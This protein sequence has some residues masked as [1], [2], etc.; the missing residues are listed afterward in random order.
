MKFQRSLDLN[1]V[2]SSVFLLGPR[3][4]GKTSLLRQL[5]AALF[6][7]LLDPEEE[8][9]YRHTPKMFWE[10]IAALPAKSVVIIDEIQ[11]VPALLDYVQKA[12]EAFSQRFILSGS[13]ARK[14]KRGG[15]N[16]LGG[17]AL[18]FHLHPLTHD[19][20][21]THFRL[22]DALAYGTM[23]R[24]SQA[25]VEGQ[26]DEARLLLRSYYTTY[27][28]E[29]IQAEALTRNV[30]AF[31]RFLQVA[32]ESNAQII[33]FAN[34]ARD[35]GVPASTVKDYFS[36]LEDTLLGNYLWP[37]GSS[38]RKK[39][40][41]KFYFFDT[42]VTRAIQGR[43]SDAPSPTESGF[44][45]ESWWVRELI[46]MRDYSQKDYGFCFWRQE[47]QEI[48]VV[49]TRGTKAIAAFECKSGREELSSATVQAF[50]SKFPKVPLYVVSAKE[51]PARR[52]SSGVEI[53]S[54]SDAIRRYHAIAP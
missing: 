23:P 6:V 31:Q 25:I 54:V 43:L 49:V 24:I 45:F 34:I 12:I 21:G 28:K 10:Q 5:K 7:D 51:G 46:R 20:L 13:S 27:I 8:L 41:P 33:E 44:L 38:E 50:Q 9:R 35:C 39:A 4:T 18:D 26:K 52:L 22:S 40:R 29:E 17:R 2:R 36:I 53:V 19:E 42:G 37:W 47:L 32:A 1:A 16:L 14:L 15:V 48:D 30:G 3:M 11:R